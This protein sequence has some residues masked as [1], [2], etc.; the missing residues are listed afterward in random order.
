MGSEKYVLYEEYV[1]YCIEVEDGEEKSK[2]KLLDVNTDSL[3]RQFFDRWVGNFY[4]YIE[5]ERLLEIIDRYG[6][7]LTSGWAN[8]EHLD[9]LLAQLREAITKHCL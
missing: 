9:K 7:S 3:T 5:P 2:N 8:S 4:I 1:F 6:Y